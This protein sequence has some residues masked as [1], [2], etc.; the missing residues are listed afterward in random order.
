M[1]CRASAARSG[2][3]ET[4]DWLTSAYRS[5]RGP[6]LVTGASCQVKP[7]DAP[8]LGRQFSQG[9]LPP[10]AGHEH[11]GPAAHGGRTWNPEP[12][13]PGRTS[14]TCEKPS[15]SPMMTAMGVHTGDPVRTADTSTFTS[16]KLTR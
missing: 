8:R 6:V 12:T 7:R 3:R 16:E 13:R 10:W 15:S 14:W 2:A 5:V 9:Q 11:V 1:R 4:V